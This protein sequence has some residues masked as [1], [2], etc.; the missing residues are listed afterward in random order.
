MLA[1]YVYGQHIRCWLS[2]I[3]WNG[4]PRFAILN[5]N[6]IPP[7]NIPSVLISF[8]VFHYLKYGLGPFIYLRD[9]M[10]MNIV[11]CIFYSVFTTHQ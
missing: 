2:W 6:F 7:Q 1:G 10:C 11:S 3:I 4:K 8:K 9:I 5:I